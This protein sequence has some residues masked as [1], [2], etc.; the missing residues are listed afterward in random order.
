MTPQDMQ[1]LETFL[2]QLVQARADGK[3]P[4]AAAMIADA[5]AR[6]PDAAYLLVQRAMLLDRAL[7][8]AQAQIASLQQQV[9]QM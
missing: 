7:V 1:A 5:A 9:Q 6:Q 4:Q 2:S 8:N 3:D